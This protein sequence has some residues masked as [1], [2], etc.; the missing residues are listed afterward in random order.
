MFEGSGLWMMGMKMFLWLLSSRSLSSD[1]PAQ[2]DCYWLFDR[3]W[4]P[5]CRYDNLKYRR[6]KI[7][8]LPAKQ[9]SFYIEVCALESLLL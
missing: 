6:G 7:R 3:S 2:L 9:T 4:T 5:A 1:L 8:Q